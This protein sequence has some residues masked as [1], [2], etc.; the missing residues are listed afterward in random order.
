[1]LISNLS[2]QGIVMTKT[3]L[4]MFC[5]DKLRCNYIGFVTEAGL[6]FHSCG[7][8]TDIPLISFLVSLLQVIT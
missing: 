2:K 4:S 3:V 6:L 1:M 8:T 5:T 7:W